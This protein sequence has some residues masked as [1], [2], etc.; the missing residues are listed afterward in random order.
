ML[1]VINMAEK[2]KF[3]YSINHKVLFLV[4]HVEIVA[5]VF[6]ICLWISA[7]LVVLSL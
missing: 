2:S 3:L 5:I 6:W 4:H 7:V 1:E